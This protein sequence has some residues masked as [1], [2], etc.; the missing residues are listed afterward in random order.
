MKKLNKKNKKIKNK[1]RILRDSAED[2]C[3]LSSSLS[4][5]L[6]LSLC[7]YHILMIPDTDEMNE[8]LEE[9]DVAEGATRV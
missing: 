4:L 1:A 3:I 6:S 5:S 2:I 9:V 8:H 7:M